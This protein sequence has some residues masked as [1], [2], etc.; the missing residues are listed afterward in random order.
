MLFQR[1]REDEDNTVI[2]SA[3]CEPISNYNKYI[4]DGLKYQTYMRI[5]TNFR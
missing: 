5:I 2:E 4:H 3:I 1:E